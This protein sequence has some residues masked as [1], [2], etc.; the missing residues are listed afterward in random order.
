MPTLSI[1]GSAGRKEDAALVNHNN[2]WKMYNQVIA[3]IILWKL[4]EYRL[5]SGGA[6]FAD[7]IAVSLF[8]NNHSPNISLAL[9]CKWDATNKKYFDSGSND[10]RMNPGKIAN[11]YHDAFREQTKI[12]SLLEL[13]SIYQKRKPPEVCWLDHFNG[14]HDRNSFVAKSD[15]II[16]FTSAKGEIPKDGG[17]SD[18]WNKATTKNKKHF[19]IG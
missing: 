19:T 7:H 1:I 11:H 12:N 16:A 3:Q 15:Y 6:A 4:E 14:F 9:P 18:T 8:L 5:V 13:D 10:W 2:Y 17:T